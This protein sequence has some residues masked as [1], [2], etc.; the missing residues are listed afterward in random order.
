M[1]RKPH[2]N[3]LHSLTRV[4]LSRAAREEQALVDH[5]FVWAMRRLQ[6]KGVDLDRIDE[7]ATK[8]LSQLDWQS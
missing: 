7:R 1:N 4:P 5:G 3:R 2:K 8:L 6:F